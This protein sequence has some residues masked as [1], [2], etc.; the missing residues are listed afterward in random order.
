MFL[1]LLDHLSEEQQKELF[2][3][4][5]AKK[6]SNE[7][8]FKRLSLKLKHVTRERAAEKLPPAPQEKEKT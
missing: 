3:D 7:A 6:Q 1:D 2:D 8:I 4:L 5:Q